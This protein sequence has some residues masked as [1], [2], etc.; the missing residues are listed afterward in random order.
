[1]IAIDDPRIAEFLI[2]WHENGRAAFEASYSNLDYD[3]HYYAKTAKNRKKYIALDEGGAGRLMLDKGTGEVWGI[4][5]YGKINKR[6]APV[7]FDAII[8]QLR[9]ANAAGRV[10]HLR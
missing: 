5:A 10:V 1:M 2:L 9:K 6:H 8:E 4:V 7:Q 3:S